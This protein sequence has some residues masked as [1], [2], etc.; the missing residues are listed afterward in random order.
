MSKFL[1]YVALLWALC[2]FFVLE[3]LAQS[4]QTISIDGKRY[5][6]HTVQKGDTV[7]SL[8]KIYS[9]ALDVVYELNP[10]A[11][12]GIKVGQ[13]LRFPLKENPKPKKKVKYPKKTFIKHEVKTGENLYS[14]ARFY[15]ISVDVLLDDNPMLD[16]TD[17]APETILYIRRDSQ[18]N[19]SEDEI[20]SDISQRVEVISTFSQDGT[21]LYMVK[22]GDTLYSISKRFGVSVDELLALNS[23]ATGYVLRVGDVLKVPS[24]TKE[25]SAEDK[26]ISHAVR[27]KLQKEEKMKISLLLPLGKPGYA[28]RNFVDFYEGF[29]LG[30]KTLAAQNGRNASLTVFNISTEPLSKIA[31]DQA[32]CSSS[33]IVGPIYEKDVLKFSRIADSLQVPLVTPFAQMKQISSNM[34]YQMAPVESHKNDK[35]RELLKKSNDICFVTSSSTD[36]HF[37]NEIESIIGPARH[38]KTFHYE[39]EHPS[40]VEKRQRKQEDYLSPSD[41]SHA[42]MGS[43]PRTI[44]V[45]ADNETDVDRIIAA[46]SSA[47]KN[48]RARSQST[49]DVTI[50]GNQKW[51]HYKNIDPTLFFENNVHLVLSYQASG[52]CDAVR[53]MNI[54]YVEEFSHM[55]SLYSYRGYD[56]ACIFAEAL[57]H[58]TISLEK[59]CFTPLQQGY[60]FRKQ[61]QGVIVNTRWSLVHYVE[62]FTLKIE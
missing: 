16:P 1:K 45:L 3:T 24:K 33:L 8:G 31:Q 6:I 30:L 48:L 15:K 34:V 60:I 32:L 53:R 59:E 40:I 22:K 47:K 5:I 58:D 11:K 51:T 18:G 55:P 28:N 12:D 56:T 7:Y 42:V 39:Y 57:Y 36:V 14:I 26:P 44:V 10:N 23:F 54:R 19:S 21:S 46:I 41:L 43:G 49:A 4:S 27:R 2:P 50:L 61:D 62:D 37:K 20:E 29:L 52:M 13:H 25:I 9:T 35:L 17:L 38:P